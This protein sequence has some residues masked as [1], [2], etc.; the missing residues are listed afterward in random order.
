[1]LDEKISQVVATPARSP[2][3]DSQG[4]SEKYVA[5]PDSAAERRLRNKIDLHIIPIIMLLYLMNFIDRTNI[6]G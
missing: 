6:G 3:P 4:A 5:A 1:M 2:E